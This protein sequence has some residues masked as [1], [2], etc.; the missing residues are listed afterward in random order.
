MHCFEIFDFWKLPWLWNLGYCLLLVTWG[1]W[2]WHRLIHRVCQTDLDILDLLLVLNSSYNS[3]TIEQ[4]LLLRACR[5]SYMRNRLV[6]KWMI[7]TFLDVV[8]RS[9]QTLRHIHHWISRK[10]LEIEAWFQ[11]TTDR[12]WPRENQM[13]TWPMTSRDPERSNLWP[14]TLR[15]QYRENSWDAIDQR[16]I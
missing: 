12:K 13:V 15:E 9:C 2:K 10:P 3:C 16:S 7:L 6:P 11:R 4:K 1:H 5:K 8:S 14:N